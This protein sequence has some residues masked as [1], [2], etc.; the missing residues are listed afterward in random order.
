MTHILC[1][2]FHI[3]SYLIPLLLPLCIADSRCE[4]SVRKGECWMKRIEQNFIDDCPGSSFLCHVVIHGTAATI[5]FVNPYSQHIQCH[6]YWGGFLTVPCPS[7]ICTLDGEFPHSMFFSNI[8]SGS[9]LTGF[10]TLDIPC[11]C[12]IL[13]FKRSASVGNLIL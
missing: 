10:H 4:T 5:L 11:R 2:A 1:P 6:L 8:H 7:Q 3:H 13:E 12:L 9:F